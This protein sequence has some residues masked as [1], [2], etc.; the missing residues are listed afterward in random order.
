MGEAVRAGAAWGVKP[1]VGLLGLSLV[2]LWRVIAHCVVVIENHL[3][4]PPERLVF[5]AVVG[6]LG[7]ALVWRG[8]RR[9]ELPSTLLGF[10][11]GALVWMGWF[12]H[13]FEALSRVMAVP[14][15]MVDG[16]YALPPNLVLLQS[17]TFILVALLLLLGMNADTG[18]RMFLWLRRHLRL[19][20]GTPS[21]GLRKQ[22]SRIVAMEY[23]LVSW[24]MYAVI[25][26]L[27]DPREQRQRF[28]GQPASLQHEDA[29]ADAGQ[30]D[31]VG[32]HHVLHTQAGRLGQARVGGR[33]VAQ[34]RDGPLHAL[35]VLGRG[36]VVEV[37]GA[38][39]GNPVQ[40][41]AAV[42]RTNSGA[43]CTASPW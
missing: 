43:A 23:V 1:W 4:E 10:A 42:S 35:C 41:V 6:A 39:G 2:L 13:G 24:F 38:H 28:G 36:V 14:P 18:C 29:A 15:L 8:L 34:Q 19:N 16:R 11:G 27:L 20:A 37:E 12:E 22:Y 31:Q 25:I 5:G 26:A 3:L 40:A 21:R 9:D 17:T 7:I 30:V 33:H 32:D